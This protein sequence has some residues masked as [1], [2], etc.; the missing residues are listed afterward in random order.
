MRRGALLGIRLCSPEEARLFDLSLQ[1]D[2]TP[3]PQA[4]P[5]VLPRVDTS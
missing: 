5:H 4:S 1:P 2:N 3:L